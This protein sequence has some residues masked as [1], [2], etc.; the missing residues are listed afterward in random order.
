MIYDWGKNLGPTKHPNNPKV[1][2][3]KE[4]LLNSEKLRQVSEPIPVIE[5]G[6]HKTINGMKVYIMLILLNYNEENNTKRTTRNIN[7]GYY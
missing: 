2:I 1:M 4:V 6:V 7:R 3:R 5:N